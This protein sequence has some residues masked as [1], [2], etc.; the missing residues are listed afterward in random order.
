GVTAHAKTQ[1]TSPNTAISTKKTN[2]VTATTTGTYTIVAKAYGYYTLRINNFTV[3]SNYKVSATKTLKTHLASG[4]A[5][6]VTATVKIGASTIAAAINK[7]SKTLGV[8]AQVTDNG[9]LKL[10]NQDGG[11]I[12]ITERAGT[13]AAATVHRKTTGTVHFDAKTYHNV[14]DGAKGMFINQNMDNGNHL[15]ATKGFTGGA[16]DAFTAN[17]YKL[18]DAG[19]TANV[20]VIRG[21][22]TITGPSAFRFTDYWENNETTHGDPNLRFNAVVTSAGQNVTKGKVDFTR[23]LN[24]S[25]NTNLTTQ[26]GLTADGI[27]YRFSAAN[28]QMFL[29]TTNILTATNAQKAIDRIDQA[30]SDLNKFRA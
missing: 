3:F 9:K 14:F 18:T 19:G 16:S 10:N 8:T 27:L 5:A 6:T 7:M 13:K 12:K 22:V 28:Q 24:K 15:I 17:G 4:S 26:G 30:I 29:K 20:T 11:N 21:T 23:T 1:Y 2:K 25:T